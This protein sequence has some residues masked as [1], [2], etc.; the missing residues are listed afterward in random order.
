MLLV[1]AKEGEED[2]PD[3]DR[4]A[5]HLH[6]H[7]LFPAYNLYYMYFIYNKNTL[8]YVLAVFIWP[9]YNYNT[10]VWPCVKCALTHEPENQ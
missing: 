9:V 5:H 4:S 8:L 2:S 10:D 1:S 7:D 3:S 6:S